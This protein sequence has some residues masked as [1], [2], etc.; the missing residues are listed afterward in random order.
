MKNLFYILFVASLISCQIEDKNAPLP[1]EGF[2]KYFGALAEQEAVDIEP[3]WNADSSEIESF[4]ILGTQQIEGESKDYFVALADASGN[5]MSSNSFGFRNLFQN[6]DTNN[7]GAPDTVQ[8]E[9]VAS[10]IAIIPSGYLVVGTSTISV[11][12]ANFEIVDLSVIT[13]AFLDAELNLRGRVIARE[14]E[15]DIV[16]DIQLDLFG[17]DVLRLSDGSFVIVGAKETSTDLDFYAIRFG[18]QPDTIYWE[19]TYGLKGGGLDDVFVRAFERDGQNIAFFGY[20]DDF[21]DNGERGTNVTYL[22]V[23]T[24][25]NIDR[26]NSTGIKDNDIFDF[27]DVLSDV[28]E[29]PGGYMAVGTSTVNDLTYSFFM[30]IDENGL[31]SRKDTLTSEFSTGNPETAGKEFLQTKALGVTASRTNDFVIVGQYPSFRTDE[32]SRDG[33]ATRGAEAMFMRVNQV[34]EKVVGFENNYGL[35][36]GNDTAVDAV[37]LPDGKIIVL[38]TIDF[39]GG[40]KMISLIKLNDT[41]QLDL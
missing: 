31:S 38:S 3:I 28:V 16:N 22:E 39:G 26:S 8:M 37:V 9:D 27:N 34:G 10:Q 7:D 17:N 40:V 25:G 35:G 18:V 30:D 21:G 5:L 13:Y 29:K 41:G 23:N 33:A 4:V 20:S 36:D 14:G 15:V 12:S 32:F 24:N 2:I 11:T 19:E 1:S 6:V